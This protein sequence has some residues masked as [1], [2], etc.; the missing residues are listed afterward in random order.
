MYVT[1]VLQAMGAD[2]YPRLVAAAN[3]NAA[4][5]R[6]VNEQTHV[7]LL[8]AGVGVI[9]TLTFAPWI[10]TL[11][12]SSDFAGATET[13]RWVCLGMALRVITWPLGYILVAKGRSA[14]FIGTDMAWAIV[15]VGLTWLCIQW[16]GLSG[17][18]VAFFASYVF[19]LAVVYPLSR[20][21]SGFRWSAVNQR[22]IVIFAGSVLAV[23]A[24]FSVLNAAAALAVGTLAV[25][26]SAAY[27]LHSLRT[28]T[29]TTLVP[30]RLSWLLRRSTRSQGSNEAPDR[31]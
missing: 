17:A 6:L 18:G 25:V 31:P 21:L 26:G 14:F 1:F 11:L 5:N 12:Y 7:S 30:K 22:A 13:L 16:L 20:R 24:A 8:L 28:L 23:Q 10:V 2:F 15:N 9:A 27:A 3:D 19:H 4:C 29:S